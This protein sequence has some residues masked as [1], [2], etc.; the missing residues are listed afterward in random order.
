MGAGDKADALTKLYRQPTLLPALDRKNPGVRTIYAE[1]CYFDPNEKLRL[2]NIK[3][4]RKQ[5]RQYLRRRYSLAVVDKIM[6][7]FNC[8]GRGEHQLV[9]NPR[10]NFQNNPK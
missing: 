8:E 6:K 9:L 7:A 10:R 1:I 5:I 2:E 3:V 4:S